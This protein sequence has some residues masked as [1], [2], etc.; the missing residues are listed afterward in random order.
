[1]S[2]NNIESKWSGGNLYFYE[3]A[4]GRS[5]TGDILSMSTAAVTIGGTSQDIDFAWYAS[6][7][8]SFV[9]DAGAGT[10]TIAG[11]DVSLTGDLTIDT[12]DI[13]LGDADDLEFGDSQ[14]VL[15]RFSTG[16]ASNHAFVLALDDTSQQ[17]H[18]TDKGAVATDWNRSA[19]THPE[20][21]IH[22]NTT[23]ATDY[24]A[25]GNHDGTT[26]Y[27]D[28]VGGTTLQFNIAGTGEVQI[29][30]SAM[31]PVTT[32][33]NALGT[34]ALMW[35][36]LFLASGAVVNF[37][38]G[39]VTVTHSSNL[40]TLDGGGLSVGASGAG[41]DIIF[42]GDTA[43]C[44]LFWDQNGDTNGAL[45]LGATGGSKGVD[46]IAYGDT[47]GNYLHWDR[48][49]DDLII[50]GTASRVLHGADAAGNDVIFYG[51]VASYAV[52]WDANGDTNGALYVGADT[53]GIMFNLYGDVTG[54]GVFWNPSTDTNGTLTIGGSGGSKGNDVIIYAATN[55]AYIQW[56]QSAAALLV[57][58]EARIDLSSATV[59]AA[60]IDG[61]VIKC[62]TLAARVTED[63]ADMK[64]LAFYF[65]NG[66]TSGDN[67][68][69]YLRQYLTGAGGGGE[70]AR[71]FT[72]CE[73][74]ACGTAHGAH[75]S[76][77][78][79]TSGSLTGLGAAMRGTLHIPQT[80]NWAGGNC[81]AIQ[82]E[83]FSDHADSD[84]VGM[85]GLSFFRVVND[86][87]AKDDVDDDAVFF[88]LVGVTSGAAKMWYDHQG[89]A[90][91]NIEEWI[92]VRTP[93]G[94]R[95]LPLYNA[96]V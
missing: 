89:A 31:S 52:T 60:N 26:A 64:F 1:M 79:G 78:F 80:N 71:I 95:W 83:I 2:V 77:N 70:A 38:N 33:S 92:K 23:P 84:P 82:A 63:T 72:T 43:D 61:G 49:A 16:D 32:D 91:A 87:S 65:D 94:I 59:A 30:S 9:L 73:D 46:F 15:M 55:G 3:K 39:D 40:L 11:V 45:Y 62:G 14:D 4:V 53:K 6:G 35:S 58:G 8:K 47:N 54:C 41:F 18:I 74:V 24:L 69:M 28:V 36:D 29:T 56:D 27:I 25:I 93:G 37:N 67:R 44:N 76:L 7:S 22:S 20:M 90:P 13:N 50:V 96:V 81:A 51:A 42:Y 5:V 88:D 57:A 19:G 21:A 48:S 12:E 75:I 17:M 86:G 85:T 10:L 34:T 68:G 66:A